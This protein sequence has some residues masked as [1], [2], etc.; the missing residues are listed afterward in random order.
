MR[1]LYRPFESGLP[2][3]TGRVYHHE[4]PGGQLSNLRQQ[5]IALGLADDFELIEDMY[6]AADRILGRIP[7]VTPSSK[8]VGDLALRLVAAKADPADFAENPQNYDIPDSVVGFMA[9]EL[10]D[11][12]GGWP[13]PFRT[14]VL[15][16]PAHLD[17]CPA[18]HRRRSATG[19]RAD[20]ASAP[21]HAEPPALPRPREGLRDQ[22]RDLRR[23]VARSAPPTTSTGCSPARSTSPRSTRGV[24]L[25]V[26]LE[27]IG[28]ADAKGIR[29]V[30]TTLNGQL[31]PVFVRDRS[32]K[33]D[34]RQAEKADTSKPGQI[35]APF[36][37]VVTLKAGV[38]DTVSGRP[39]GRLDR[40]DEDGGGDHGARR[41]RG[42]APRD[43]RDA[44]GRGRRPF[45]RHPS[46]PLAW[47]VA[48]AR[49][50]PTCV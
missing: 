29:T 35:A 6:A 19:W 12:P 31:R 9:G 30:M 48:P 4:I 7:K 5:A 45:G 39:A 20:A 40:G 25:Y 43:R 49:Q 15:G 11:L 1:H 3:P 50:H 32:I 24:Q 17:R 18:A 37:G 44:A 38:G 8:V 27:A 16:R 13:E 10:G 26:G 28:E 47:R 34:V 23:P 46:R 36:S 21:P 41:R 2:G 22:P 33:V 42:R 14:K